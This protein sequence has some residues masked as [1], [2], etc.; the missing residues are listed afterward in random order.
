MK[1]LVTLVDDALEPRLF[2]SLNRRYLKVGRERFAQ[3]HWTTF[4][5]PLDERPRNAVEEAVQALRRRIPGRPLGVEW[6]LGRM[7]PRNVPI[8]LH[9]DRDNHLFDA[10][11]R[12]VHP[13]ISSV[14]YM[15]PV[16]GGLL[17]VADQGVRGNRSIE[18]DPSAHFEVIRPAPNRFIWFEGDRVHGVLNSLNQVPA[19]RL[20][21]PPG[22]IRRSVIINWWDRP[23]RGVERW[24]GRIY[25]AL[26]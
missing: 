12:W 10:T 17:L 25:P 14:L 22:R 19:A 6:W 8:E 13:R 2:R 9:A 18:L 4:W 23:P 20:R 3:S 16:P 24:D 26:G 5:Y 21:L 1:R 11:G 7:D 15:N